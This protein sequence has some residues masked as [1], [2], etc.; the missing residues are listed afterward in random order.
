MPCSIASTVSG[1][2]KADGFQVGGSLF[3]RDRAMFADI[4]LLG[5]RIAG[6][7][8]FSRSTVTGVLNGDRLQV[9]GSLIVRDDGTFARISM[10]GARIA[11]NAVLRGSTVN[12]RSMPTVW[13][14]EAA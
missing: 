3:L 13:R 1:M 2:L 5:A 12:G 9:E 4:R 10:L 11:G 6:N 8:E 14:S 7:A